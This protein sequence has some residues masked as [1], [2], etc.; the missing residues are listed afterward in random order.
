V[1][2]F[3]PVAIAWI[4]TGRTRKPGPGAPPGGAKRRR[5]E[6]AKK[7]LSGTLSGG[8]LRP[9]A[10]LVIGVLVAVVPVTVR[11][12]VASGDFVILT[13]NGGLNFYLGNGD[14]STGGCV[15]SDGH[16]MVADPPGKWIA[17]ADLGREL[18]A[19]EISS[20]WASRA[21]RFI[22]E[23]P[24]AWLKL[25]V[26]KLA[27][28]MN[29]YEL[30]QLEYYDF[31]K[32]Y[33]AV[34][35]LPLPSFSILAPLG[36][37]GFWLSFRR[38]RARILAL[39]FAI[40]VLSIVAFF[41][42]ARYRLPAIPPLIIGAG[43]AVTEIAR[44]VRERRWRWLVCAAVALA[45]LLV[46]V[47]SNPYGVDRRAAFA[48]PHFRLGI[49]FGQRG[50]ID[51]AIEEYRKSIAL[52]PDYMKSHMNLGALLAERGEMEAAAEAFRS[53]IRL[54]PEYGRARV[55]LAM[56]FQGLGDYEAALAQ[57]DTALKFAP[58]DAAARKQ[59][60][61]V[62][63]RMGLEEEARS[64]LAEALSLDAGGTERAEIEFYMAK[65]EGSLRG[66]TPEAALLKISR[67]DSL[68][69]VGRVVE[70]LAEL[71]EAARI[72]P[73]SGEPLM[74][75]AL[76]KKDLGLTE[77]AIELMRHALAIDPGLEHG[78]FGLG[79]LLSDLGR[80]D[81]AIDEYERELR[82]FPDFAPA[83]LNL[84]LTYQH[85]AGNPD[86][87]AFHYR[88]YLALGG[89][90]AEVAEALLRDLCLARE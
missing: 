66:E 2:V 3:V 90:R 25:L 41:V 58:G 38:R 68:I 43:F 15:V 17:E 52:D 64:E 7:P 29:A 34:L 54:E 11:N 82:L 84:G 8:W 18:T 23:E 63:Y 28:V 6:R 31:Q 46:L 77:E 27:F 53:A 51:R 16:D 79:V 78:H 9:A 20:Y 86:R 5:P 67:S 42:L 75:I 59:R 60:G 74:R 48:Q 37:V 4:W 30:P 12:Y 33:S 10:F 61:I 57:A 69:Q 50:L 14:I 49:I 1:L 36:L 83:H 87:A 21:R 55:N 62:L 65:I 45:A 81:E 71:T 56:A 89:E 26:R 88:R 19:S 13:S 32:R 47:N 22:T 39:F 76:L 72:A 40:Y 35:S 80:H 44:H 70:A 73:E 85:H 24:G